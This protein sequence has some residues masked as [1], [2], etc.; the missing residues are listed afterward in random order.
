VNAVSGASGNVTVDLTRDVI[1]WNGAAGIQANQGGGGTAT[2]T[3]GFS[4]LSNNGSAVN[5]TGSGQV[6]TF[7]Y[8]H[9]TGPTG[10]GFTGSI[11]VQ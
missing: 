8:N 6:K 2:V 11:G 9:V 3:V 10:T 7:G 5:A 1:S 4:T